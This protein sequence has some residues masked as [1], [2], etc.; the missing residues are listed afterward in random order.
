MTKGNT[1]VD[2]IFQGETINTPSMLCVEDCRDAL[3]WVASVGGLAGTIARADANA[4]VVADWLSESKPFA[5]L[6]K[7]PEIA[8]NTSI[9]LTFTEPAVA[10]KSVPDRVALANRICALLEAEK[11]AFDIG[12]YRDA[13]PGLRIWAGSTVETSDIAALLPWLDWAYAKAL[14]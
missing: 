2:G 8:S 5:N 11:V 1:L 10:G 7:R 13:P 9:C 12:H 6:A 14:G 3:T 4:G